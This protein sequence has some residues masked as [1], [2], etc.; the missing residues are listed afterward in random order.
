MA[1]IG[2]A[3]NFVAIPVAAVAVPG[4]LASL[5]L[6]PF[7][8]ASSALAAGSGVSLHLLELIAEWGARVPLGHFVMNGVPGSAVPWLLLLLLLC[9]A[10]PR[11]GNASLASGRLLLAGVAGVWI[12]LCPTSGGRSLAR[13]D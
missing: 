5:L 13:A 6:A 12:A 8:L 11:H 1:P 3:L 7:T 10:T 9:W 2:I 4:V